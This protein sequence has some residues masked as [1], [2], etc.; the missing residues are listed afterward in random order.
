MCMQTNL[1]Q[2][3]FPVQQADN[4]KGEHSLISTKENSDTRYVK[5]CMEKKW[6]HN[7]AH[8]QVHE[9]SIRYM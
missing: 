9:V 4:Y 1:S 2:E 6:L 7:F 5:Q 8:V 3:H